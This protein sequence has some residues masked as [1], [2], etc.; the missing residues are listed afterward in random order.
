[1]TTLDWKRVIDQLVEMD[2]PMVQFIGGEPTM[3]PDF[4]ELAYYA[5]SQGLQVEVFTNLVKVTPELW[6]LFEHRRVQL[7]TSYYSDDAQEHAEITNGVNAHRLTT[8]HIEG[9]VRRG[10]PLRA[11][12]IDIRD[13]QRYEEAERVLR[14]LGV[15]SIGFDRLREVGRGIRAGEEGIKQLCGNCVS[16]VIAISPDGMVWPCVFSR[17]LPV[18]NVRLRSLGEILAGDKYAKT[19]ARL[20]AEFA[21]RPGAVVPHGMAPSSCVPPQ[22]SPTSCSP[23][24][25]PSCIPPCAPGGSVADDEVPNMQSGGTE[26]TACG[27]NCSPCT[28]TAVPCRPMGW[29]HPN[30]SPTACQPDQGCAPP[31]GPYLYRGAQPAQTGCTP[32]EGCK[33]S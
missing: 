28:P 12:I 14:A 29:N 15:Q 7:A 19:H 5:L 10:I 31:C 6:L 23:G 16:G 13:G 30:I 27:P 18:G 24:C 22:C 11:G 33:P 26:T 25:G 17:F 4:L 32:D 8:A 2:A 20:T 1:M 3:H 21:G 9:A